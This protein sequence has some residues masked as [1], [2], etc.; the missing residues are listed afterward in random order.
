MTALLAAA[1][2][3][4]DI[5]LVAPTGPGVRRPVTFKAQPFP[6]QDVRIQDGPFK[7]AM[8]RDGQYLLAL[9][10]DRLLHTFRL[11]AGLPSTAAPL[12]GWESPKVELRGHF[13]GHY[14]SACA[15][16][17]AS[18]SDPRYRDRVALIVGELAKCQAALGPSGYLSAFSESFIDRVETTGKVWAP[19]YTL[20]KIFAGLLDAHA[21]CDNAQALVV[22]RKF[23]D[24]L[25]ARNARLSDEQLEKMLDVEH[26]GI[27]ES[28]ARLYAATG[29]PRHLATAR[30]LWHRRVLDPLANREDRL[31]GLHANTQFPKVI[32]AALLYELTGDRRY[33]TTAEFFW[34]RVVHHH[35][36]VNGGN[37]DHEHF[38]PPDRLAERV[39]PWTAESCNTY[40]MLKLTRH[41]F[42]W[43]AGAAQA[44][45]YERALYNHI[46]ASQDPRTGMMAYHIPLYGRWFMPYNTTND[47]FWCCTG[48]GVENHA[49][50]GD[51]IY[52]HDDEGLFVNLFI[53]SELAWREKGLILGQQTKFPEEE[54][55]RLKISCGQ[56]VAMTLRIRRPF[57][58][59]EGFAVT[60]NGQPAS[61]DT[62]PGSYAAIK[63]SWNHGDRVEVRLPMSLRL[64]PMP[65]NPNR[66][67]ICYGPVV[68]AGALGTEGIVP[69]MPYAKGQGDFFRAALP[70][71]PVLVTD[72]RPVTEWVTQAAN[73]PLRFRTKG[74][75]RPQDVELL[76]FHTLPPQRY[77]LYWDLLTEADWQK[78]EAARKTAE[79]RERELAARTLD[80]VRIG[81]FESER[82]HAQKGDRTQSG[83]HAGRLWRHATDGGFFSYELKTDGSPSL[84]LCE[85]WGDDAGPREFDILVDGEKVATQKLARNKPGEFFEVRYPLPE[86]LTR[87]KNKLT[88]R[89]QAQ[90]GR[91]AGGLFGL[92]LLRKEDT[93]P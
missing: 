86:N 61:V 63:R 16:M 82:A 69:P 55:T 14:L 56:P 36:Y 58:A 90:P 40:N 52:W 3:W 28:M 80:V 43:E 67:A 32:G 72:N 59:Q 57:W 9:E 73:Q 38:G 30:R 2:G 66:A 84:L 77:T 89:F 70:P 51:S 27:N 54:I 87:N 93:T 17:H 37:S 21:L 24:W 79:R 65:D 71:P 62:K 1:A 29:D 91:T 85:Y 92:R 22:A 20:H 81:D 46:L 8:E 78:R 35:S 42:A 49:K 75:G 44:D 47:S 23:G 26:G 34:D 19:Y 41:L 45:Y 83:V 7:A 74:V 13:L 18:T 50:Y 10:P 39:S 53:P 31:A 12:G 64:E 33:Q 15:L 68:L 5:S 25:A 11:N 88:V 4:A 60:V 6:L 48:T 76:A